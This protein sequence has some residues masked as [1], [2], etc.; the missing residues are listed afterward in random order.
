M[1]RFTPDVFMVNAKLHFYKISCMQSV[2]LGG[3]TPLAFS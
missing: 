1:H 2:D 3:P